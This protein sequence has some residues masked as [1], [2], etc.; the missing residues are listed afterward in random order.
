MKI[1]SVIKF[2]ISLAIIFIITGVIPFVLYKNANYNANNLKPVENSN[3]DGP[4]GYVQRIVQ[5]PDSTMQIKEDLSSAVRG[6][7]DVIEEKRV[8][9]N[10]V[11]ICLLVIASI[12]IITVGLL[13]YKLTE[14]KSIGLGIISGGVLSTLTYIFIFTVMIYNAILW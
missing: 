4:A 13:V 6:Y 1:S 11:I 9:Y 10:N 14:S 12:S 8:T 2:I 7:Q 5:N 3:F